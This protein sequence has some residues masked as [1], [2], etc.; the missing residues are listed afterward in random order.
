MLRKEINELPELPLVLPEFLLR[1]LSLDGN[2]GDAAGVVDHLNFGWARLANFTVKH[3]E[4]AEHSAV[5]L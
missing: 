5:G 4:R 3:P 1:A 2:S